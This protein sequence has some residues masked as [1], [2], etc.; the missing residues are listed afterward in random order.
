MKGVPFSFRVTAINELSQFV[1]ICEVGA[2]R[3]TFLTGV[4]WSG[5]AD[6]KSLRQT[7]SNSLF[8]EPMKTIPWQLAL[9]T[10][11]HLAP[12]RALLEPSNNCDLLC[13]RNEIS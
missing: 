9:A 8:T 10:I 11:P 1:A 13:R 3:G 12:R 2:G 7:T 6:S 5:E 4:G